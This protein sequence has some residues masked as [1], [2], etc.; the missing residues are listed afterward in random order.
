MIDKWHNLSDKNYINSTINSII[1]NIAY[2]LFY[3]I[4]ENTGTAK[5][6]KDT[7]GFVY[8]GKSESECK[9]IADNKGKK[10]KHA[11]KT[12]KERHNLSR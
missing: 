5:I 12:L 2:N 8:S 1:D 11:L 6:D 4:D 9:R 3:E 7:N 10:I